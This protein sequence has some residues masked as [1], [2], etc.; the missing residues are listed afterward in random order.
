VSSSYHD[1]PSVLQPLLPSVRLKVPFIFYFE[2]RCPGTAFAKHRPYNDNRNRF[3]NLWLPTAKS[4]VPSLF[5]RQPAPPA[6]AFFLLQQL[7]PTTAF[8][9]GSFLPTT[10]SFCGGF[11]LLQQSSPTIL[12]ISTLLNTRGSTVSDRQKTRDMAIRTLISFQRGQ[13]VIPMHG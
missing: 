7:P 5:L 9:Y 6:T 1:L 10:S 8:S 2:S 13:I 11:P 4:T 12:S 3:L